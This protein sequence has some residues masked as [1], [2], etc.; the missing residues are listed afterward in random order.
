MY[1]Y[2]YNIHLRKYFVAA[3]VAALLKALLF[4]AHKN[5]LIADKTQMK[6]RKWR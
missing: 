1:V 3:K 6:T 4:D 2:M 5:E